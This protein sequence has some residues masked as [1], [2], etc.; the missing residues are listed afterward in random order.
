MHKSKKMPQKDKSLQIAQSN[1]CKPMS[2][3][4]PPAGIEVASPTTQLS[5][6]GLDDL[7]RFAQSAG[8]RRENGP[9][10]AA[11]GREVFGF[12]RVT[13]ICGI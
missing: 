12:R 5:D 13:T 1:R 2:V 6:T 9:V 3:E 4:T 10:K 8:G 11:D 7:P